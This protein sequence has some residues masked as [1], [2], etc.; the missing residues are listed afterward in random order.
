MN[1]TALSFTGLLT[2]VH[3]HKVHAVAI[4]PMRHFRLG[5]EFQPSYLLALE[6][7]TIY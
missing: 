6:S 1:N 7:W 5:P 2:T 4:Y 3:P